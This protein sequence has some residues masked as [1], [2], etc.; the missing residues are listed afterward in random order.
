MLMFEDRKKW[1][2]KKDGPKMTR[3]FTMKHCVQRFT[4]LQNHT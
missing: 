3:P 2:R 4:V 1:L